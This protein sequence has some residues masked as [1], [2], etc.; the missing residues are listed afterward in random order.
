MH[1]QH[2]G[3]CDC[4][5]YS[6]RL[7]GPVRNCT[8]APCP[9][10]PVERCLP[11][12][13]WERRASCS[14]SPFSRLVEALRPRHAPCSQ[15]RCAMLHRIRY[16]CPETL[17]A[18]RKK[19][20][21]K[22][23]SQWVMLGVC[24]FLSGLKSSPINIVPQPNEQL[25]QIQW[26]ICDACKPYFWLPSASG[27]TGRKQRTWLWQ[28]EKNYHFIWFVIICRNFAP[29]HHQDTTLYYLRR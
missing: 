11:M 6:V 2:D 9:N 14:G 8:S 4:V 17:I 15:R 7:V 20:K 10:C 19:H 13:P 25:S 1:A 23:G 28:V 26:K 5:L 29:T 27:A 24:L 21:C 18:R 3:K 12:I 16:P 22:K